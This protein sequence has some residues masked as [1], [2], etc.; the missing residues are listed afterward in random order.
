MAVGVRAWFRG[1]TQSEM[2]SGLALTE[3]DLGGGGELGVRHDGHV[4][5][6]R[7]LGG[8]V[9]RRS[10]RARAAPDVDVRQSM[11]DHAE[12]LPGI[13]GQL[14][15]GLPVSGRL[16]LTPYVRYDWLPDDSR[17]RARWGLEVSIALGA[18]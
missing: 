11:L 10:I 7:T 3:R 9:S 16:L 4:A 6:M 15:V 14:E 13:Y 17:V 12:W 5:P 1:L 18:R 8:A 2:P